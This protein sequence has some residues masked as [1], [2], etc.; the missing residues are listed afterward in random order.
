[1]H[2]ATEP[3]PYEELEQRC[4]AAEIDAAARACRPARRATLPAAVGDVVLLHGMTDPVLVYGRRSA[5]A[6]HADRLEFWRAPAM[7][8]RPTK[9][10]GTIHDVREV[11]HG[12]GGTTAERFRAELF[13]LEAAHGQGRGCC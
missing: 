8:G 2:H 4:R 3:D 1:M 10:H 5:W 11:L 12:Q 6:G 13:R 9:I 7:G